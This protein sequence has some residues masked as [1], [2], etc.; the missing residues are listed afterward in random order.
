MA[1]VTKNGY[2]VEHASSLLVME[3]LLPE[4]QHINGK[5][6]TDKYTPTS[7]VESVTLIDVMRILPYAPRFR[8]IGSSN[9]GGW[10]NIANEG[11]YRNA[12]QSEHFTI[13][14]DLIY[15]EGVPITSVQTYSNP[16]AL[17]EKV[18]AQL[19][20]SAGMMVNVITY[21]KQIEGYFRDSFAVAYQGQIDNLQSTDITS[22]EIANAVFSGNS[23]YQ[24]NQDGSY[25]DAFIGANSSLTDGVPE[26]GA[27][28]VPMEERQ[29]FVT[30]EFNRVMKRQYEQNASEASARILAM[31]FINPFNN[32]PD[33]R[34]NVNTGLCGTYD[35]V[36]LFLINKSVK[37]QV[38]YALGLNGKAD[39][40]AL[41][42]K[43][44]AM[45]VYAGGTCRGIVGPTIEANVNTYYGGVYLLPKM[46]VGVEVL[47]GKSIK[48]VVDGGWT[49]ENIVAL[50]KAIVFTPLDGVINKGYQV[51]YNTGANDPKTE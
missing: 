8:K 5:G 37:E 34:I 43:M 48:M 18:M 15:D 33:T 21:A 22:E 2:D 28:I 44:R 45:I 13:P 10:H 24:A 36:D 14:I 16:I 47:S 11:G 1:F 25:A 41:L 23:T 27:M 38:I 9:N 12:P 32:K 50:K 20:K 35:G 51:G 31:G 42:D 17:K 4:I 30:N 26:I 19:I 3:N 49:A 6:C 40:I 29:A 7:D 46:K 39:E